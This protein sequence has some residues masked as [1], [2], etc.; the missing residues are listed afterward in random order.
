MDLEI[1]KPYTGRARKTFSTTGASA[2]HQSMA[3]ECDVNR[4]MDKW[5]KTGVLEHRNDFQG[6]YGDFTDVPMDYH[7]SI[8]AVIEAEQMFGSLPA[9]IRKKFGNDPGLFLDFVSDDD[10]HDEL[11][12][13]GLANQLEVVDQPAKTTNPKPKNAKPAPNPEIPDETPPSDDKT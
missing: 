2:T 8:N 10:N 11:V 1:R 9:Q 6:Q 3:D 5:A 7:E 4:I 12:K 13:L